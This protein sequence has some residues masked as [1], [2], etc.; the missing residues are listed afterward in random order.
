[1]TLL[2]VRRE[3]GALAFEAGEGPPPRRAFFGVRPCE[4]AAIAAQDRVF[5]GGAH[6]DPAYAAR[7]AACLLIAVQCTRPGGTCF[8]ASLGTG[9]RAAAGFDLALTEVADGAPRF[10]AEVG[11]PRGAALLEAAGARPASAE[12]MAEADDRLARAAEGMGRTLR[13]DGLRD[14]LFRRYE[15]PA[16]DEIGKRCLACANCTQVCPTCFCTTVEDVT[17][18]AGGAER[19]RRWDSCFAVDFSYVHGGSVRTSPGA[20]YRQWMTHKLAA[21]H[22]QFGTA[23]C[24]G[25]GR[26]ITWCPAGIDLTDEARRLQGA[27]VRP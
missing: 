10:V 15:D 11:T 2:R 24:V 21:W 14:L 22:D 18:L 17:D 1:V 5:L 9:P 8:C 16:W 27:E 12:E 3:D 7:R 26:C 23:G 4:L 6:R 19:R 25:C 20:R 13:V